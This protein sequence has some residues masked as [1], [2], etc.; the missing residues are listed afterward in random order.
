MS[1][2][3]SFLE[4]SEFWLS[5]SPGITEPVSA[6]STEISRGDL[7]AVNAA[8]QNQFFCIQ[9]LLQLAAGNRWLAVGNEN[10]VGVLTVGTVHIQ[11]SS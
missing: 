11:A 3:L 7:F 5:Q 8:A 2:L 1:C 4:Q 6:I 10:D 9:H